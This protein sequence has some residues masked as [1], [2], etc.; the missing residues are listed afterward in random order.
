MKVIVQNGTVT[1]TVRGK[2]VCMD[3]QLEEGHVSDFLTYVG[4]FVP[5]PGVT[6]P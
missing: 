3:K 6:R 2:V 1:V 5:H 4:S